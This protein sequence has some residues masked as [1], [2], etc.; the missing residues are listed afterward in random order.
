M[1]TAHAPIIHNHT[2]STI[3][4]IRARPIIGKIRN[5]WRQRDVVLHESD[6]TGW[7]YMIG[8]TFDGSMI[9]VTLEEEGLN[10]RTARDYW[11]H[12]EKVLVRQ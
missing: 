10:E 9:V 7:A 3:D 11:A 2:K 8:S 6:T 4:E 1:M 12:G 5:E